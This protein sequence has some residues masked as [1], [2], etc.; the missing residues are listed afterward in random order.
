M[1]AMEKLGGAELMT[2]GLHVLTHC[3][4]HSGWW[5]ALKLC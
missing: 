2:A 5:D 3:C 1:K 4:M